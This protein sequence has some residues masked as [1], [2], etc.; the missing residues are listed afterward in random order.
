LEKWYDIFSSNDKERMQ[1]EMSQL[2]DAAREIKS[3][4]LNFDGNS[5]E[6]FEQQ[7]QEAQDIYVNR[8]KKVD[9]DLFGINITKLDSTTKN[10]LGISLIV[11]IFLAVIF[12]LNWIRNLRKSNVRVKR[13]KNKKNN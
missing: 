7:E 1:I 2:E 12:G 9:L 8:E 6:N 13:N 10:I 3:E 5:G 4:D 11:S